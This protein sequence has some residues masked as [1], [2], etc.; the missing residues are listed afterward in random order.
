MYHVMY[1]IKFVEEGMKLELER[2]WSVEGQ[3]TGLSW[4]ADWQKIPK[5]GGGRQDSSKT[6]T[7]GGECPPK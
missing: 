2:L 5:G 1:R 4:C 7:R 3:H 6:L